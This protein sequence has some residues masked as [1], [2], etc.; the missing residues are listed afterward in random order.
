[1]II[2][3]YRWSS[4]CQLKG[5][6]PWDVLFGW[7]THKKDGIQ[8]RRNCRLATHFKSR[9]SACKFLELLW[10]RIQSPSRS[11]RGFLSKARKQ[12]RGC[13]MRNVCLWSQ[14]S[15]SLKGQTTQS[16]ETPN[17]QN[18]DGDSNLQPPFQR[19]AAD[20]GIQA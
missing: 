14:S 17:R 11:A 10:S 7:L 4:Y 18:T 15:F 1:M 8:A 9:R 3:S 20:H 6:I 2:S 12:L 19:S 13:Q 16:Q 5:Q